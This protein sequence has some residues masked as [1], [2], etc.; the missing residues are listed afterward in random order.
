MPRPKRVKYTAEERGIKKD[1]INGWTIYLWQNGDKYEGVAP[2]KTRDGYK[3]LFCQGYEIEKDPEHKKNKKIHQVWRAKMRVK[4]ILN[5]TLNVLNWYGKSIINK[6][7]NID[8]EKLQLKEAH[9]AFQAKKGQVGMEDLYPIRKF[10]T[11]EITV[12]KA[13]EYK[14]K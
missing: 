12:E 4:N 8:P 1:T 14:F 11:K 7:G 13:R 6:E 2:V 10:P 3:G 5:D 9:T